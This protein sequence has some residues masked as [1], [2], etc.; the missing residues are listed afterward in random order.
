MQIM[1][2]SNN[3]SEAFINRLSSHAVGIIVSQ[4]TPPADQA[5]TR[6]GQTFRNTA[7][8]SGAPLSYFGME[9]YITARVLIEGLQRAGRQLTRE[10]L[11]QALESLKNHD[12][13]GIALS[14]GPDDHT[15]SEYMELTIIGKERKFRR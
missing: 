2:L 13:G 5:T 1:T 15:G 7:R 12:L 3:S 14:Y 11:I 9:G 10:R 8:T 6:L 4:I